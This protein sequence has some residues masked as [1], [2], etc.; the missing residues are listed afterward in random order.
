MSSESLDPD[1]SRVERALD[2]ATLTAWYARHGRH[3]LPWRQ[4]RDPYAVLVSEVMLQQTQ[5]SRVTPYYEQWLARWPN[6]PAL[7]AA[8]LADVIRLWSGLGYNLSLIHI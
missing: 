4:T 2:L 7:A 5:V 1:D 8:P 3:L 6:A